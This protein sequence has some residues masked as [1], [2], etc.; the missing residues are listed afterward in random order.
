M[1]HTPADIVRH[2]LIG[3]AVGSLPQQNREWPIFVGMEPDQRDLAITLYNTVG[4]MFGRHNNDGSIAEH[5]GVFIR[6]R[7]TSDRVAY[8]KA[9]EIATALN[10]QVLRTEVSIGNSDYVFESASQRGSI[11]SLGKD[12]DNSNRYLCTLNYTVVISN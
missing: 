2:A 4:V 6:V 11:I 5:H 8:L 7:A 1:N 10:E 9:Q 3:L 12:Q